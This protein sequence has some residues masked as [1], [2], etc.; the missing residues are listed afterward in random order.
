VLSGKRCRAFRHR[1]RG[2]EAIGP[3]RDRNSARES[4]GQARMPQQRI[5]RRPGFVKKWLRG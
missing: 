5:V 2:A 1:V 3:V 4:A